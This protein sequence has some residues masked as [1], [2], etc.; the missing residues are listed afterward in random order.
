MIAVRGHPGGHCSE[1]IPRY[2]RVDISTAYPCRGLLGDSAWTHG[3]D[4]TTHAVLAKTT[5]RFLRIETIPRGFLSG[6]GHLLD[7]LL[8]S[9]V[10]ASFFR[11]HR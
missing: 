8:G 10:N 7:D 6:I 5:L 1:E 2:N 4:S 9:L 11:I 3:T